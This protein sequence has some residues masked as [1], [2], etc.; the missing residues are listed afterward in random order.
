MVG[1]G[2][3]TGQVTC[4]A[5]LPLVQFTFEPASMRALQQGHTVENFAV[6]VIVN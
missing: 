3:A 5:L 4:V 2:A 1:T 6:M